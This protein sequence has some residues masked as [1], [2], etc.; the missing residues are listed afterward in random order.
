M[1]IKKSKFAS[2]LLIV[3]LIG[4]QLAIGQNPKKLGFTV[5]GLVTDASGENLIGATVSVRNGEK[6]TAVAVTDERGE[7]SI[8][9]ISGKDKLEFTYL[10]Y[11]K[12]VIMIKNTGT[13]NV[14]MESDSKT[15]GDVVVTGYQT[16]SRERA[17]GAFSKVTGDKLSEKRLSSLSTLLKGELAGY[18]ASS[19]LIRGTTSMNGVTN[20]LYVIDG[21][22]IENTRYNSTGSIVENIPNLNLED[23][24]SITILKDAAAASIY[25]ARA[26]NGVIVIVTKKAK[27][28]KTN[29]SFSSSMTYS[30]YSYYKKHL[31]D[32][33]DIIDLEK[34]WAS[35]N[36][37]LQ[38]SGATAYAQSL[39]SNSVYPSQG[40]NTILNYYAGNTTADQE[41]ATLTKLSGQGYH[42]YND[43]AKY[44]KRDALYQ[45]YNL[46]LGKA[47]DKNNFNASISY[48]TNKLNDK[49]SD[50]HSIGIDLKNSL[51]ITNWLTF[52]V[53]TY[54]YFNNATTQTF[55][56]LSP[57]Y[58]Y[59]PYDGL[60]NDDG[61]AYTSKAS[62]R[63]SSDKMNIINKY[64]LY[65]L[66]ITTLDELGR[67]LQ[68]TNNFINR[69]Y[70]KLNIEFT[71][72][73]KYN[74][75]FQ[76][77]YG[78][79]RTKKMY[80]KDSYYVRNLVDS[81]ATAS[82]GKATYNLPYGN[83]LYRENQNSNAYTFRQQLNFD[84]TFGD[85][86][87]LT[88]IA[89]HEVRQSKLE[90]NNQTLYNYDPD[91]LTFSLVNASSLAN[92]SGTLLGNS[93]F[94][95]SNIAYNRYHD[96]RFISLYSNGAY[97]YNSKYT[98]TGSIRLDRSN[99]W[100]TNVKYQ[101]KPIWS[102]GG[103]WNV[104]KEQFF[105]VSWIDRLKLRLSYGIG[106]NIAKDAAPYMTANYSQNNNVGGTQGTISGRPNPD[107]SWEKTITTN[108]GIDFSLLKGRLAGSVELYN[109]Q[110]KN[111]LA[112]SMGVATEGYGYST[113]KINNGEMRNRGIELTLNGT[114]IRTKDF[115]WD[116]TVI[117]GYNKNKVTY[118]NVE[119]P[120]YYLQLDYP[121]S[122]PRVGNPYASIYAYKW[123]GL[124]DKGLPQVYDAS[125][126]KTTDNPS[127]LKAIVY[128]GT[129]EPTTN[130]SLNMNFTYKDFDLSCLWIYEGGNKMRN[131]DQPMLGSSYN[132]A[133]G[134]Y[135]TTLSPVNK[136]ITKRWRK[137]GD[138]TT[139]NVPR[140]V[141]GES[142]DYNYNS[143]TIYNYADINVINAGNLRL[144]NVSLAYHLP[145]ALIHKCFL[146]NARLQFNV[147]NALTF[148][149][150]RTAKYLLGGYN[151]PNYVWGLYL[152]F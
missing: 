135:V 51:N 104:D 133:L 102:V 3:L 7:Y 53:G 87:D 138:E 15:L 17:T 27:K 24:E 55:N 2:L 100:G 36:P 9:A 148:A 112:N 38:T 94:S 37:N 124:S 91:M 72:Y 57:G 98:A 30:P 118:V 60:V 1:R 96:D 21:F 14:A 65:N 131:T 122:Y 129:T 136:D 151:S 47:T 45:Q 140:A 99:L 33:A 34:E 115:S 81:Y 111:L 120:V 95:Q 22:P 40:I 54:T 88:I 35:N 82:N 90:Y 144:S 49:Y 123:A 114:I 67:N 32:A 143:A 146:S 116:A 68:H 139:T 46:S 78:T 89:G 93:T 31:T 130:T 125:G 77:E 58:S 41:Q 52:D 73:L 109:K 83:I 39:L 4:T 152:N 103:G 106:G 117:Y 64:G 66:D 61:T 63:L 84:K 19:G 69:T 150:G 26:A 23:I 18:A 105:H 44:A 11:V 86:H 119:A 10:G 76:Y 6:V 20:P 142:S 25:G 92:I 16:I 79:D 75:M 71:K 127:D 101:K 97:T 74:V 137:A 85:K 28:G 48:Q 70:G 80:E 107:L 42:Y 145:T 149:H 62:S 147:E 13:V 110:G 108:L 50:N 12:K 126:N 121:S 132:S 134:G 141:F 56:A 5:H 29:I 8:N 113:Y 59:M 43:V 128:A